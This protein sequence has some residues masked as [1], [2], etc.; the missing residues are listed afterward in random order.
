M[1]EL[2]AGSIRVVLR[3]LLPMDAAGIL[4]LLLTVAKAAVHRRQLF[5][6]WHLFDIGVACDAF[7]SG[8]R[9]RFQGGRVEARRYAGLALSGTRAGIVA[10]GTV[11][12]MQLR[13]LLAAETRG[14]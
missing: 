10:A 4:A 7:N 5:R 11:V 2:A 12:G 13:C 14:Q 3:R 8:M 9:G 1:A 6:V